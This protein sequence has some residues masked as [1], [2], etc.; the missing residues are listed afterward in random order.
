LIVRHWVSP[1]LNTGREFL[2]AG[3]RPPSFERP[4]YP[5]S[6]PRRGTRT[7]Y[8]IGF[9]HVTTNRTIEDAFR[10]VEGWLRDEKASIKSAQP[11]SR[12]EASHGKALQPMGWK[13]DA[14]KTLTFELVQQGPN[15]F[16]RVAI[17]PPFLNI[18]DVTSREDQARANWNELLAELW[19]RFGERDAVREAVAKPPVDW[20][21]SR[22]RGKVMAVSG[23]ILLG[24]LV[25]VIV[26]LPQQAIY[27]APAFGALGAI[28][29][30]NGALTIRAGT[31]SL[32][33]QREAQR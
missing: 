3:P 11:P 16:V 31:K 26:L 14:K 20:N 15:V 23:L 32:A 25:V 10:I 19:T 33:R 22:M 12:I 4:I 18:S 5:D 9:E 21:V 17:A 6:H 1:L 27:A 13:K 30:V 8:S 7:G 29:V 24:I 28:L 2:D